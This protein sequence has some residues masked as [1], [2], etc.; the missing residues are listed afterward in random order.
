MSLYVAGLDLGQTTDPSALCII[1]IDGTPVQLPYEGEVLGLPSTEWLYTKI[2]PVR[3]FY[4]RHVERFKLDLKYTDIISMVRQRMAGVPRPWYLAVD[5]TGVGAGVI[6]MMAAMNPIAIMITAGS[7]ITMTEGLIGGNCGWNVPKRDLI[8]SAQVAMQNRVMKFAETPYKEAIVKELQ[9]FKMKLTKAGSD[10]YEA[11]R[12]S[13]HDDLVLALSIGC[14]TGTE[15]LRQRE[16]QTREA[17]R[18]SAVKEYQIS[19]V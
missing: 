10:T 12:E 11:W 7:T 8:A 3:R 14:W 17:I 4:V 9:N 5:K 19:P 2:L 13:D 15:I 18:Q 16:M 1:E 6:E